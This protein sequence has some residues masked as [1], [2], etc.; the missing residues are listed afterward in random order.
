[1]HNQTC[2]VQTYVVQKAT[3][4]SFMTQVTSGIDQSALP[5]LDKNYE[6]Y[7][8]IMQI[9]HSTFYISN[10]IYLFIHLFIKYMLVAQKVHVFRVT[11]RIQ[12]RM[13]HPW[14]SEG[15]DVAQCKTLHFFLGNLNRKTQKKVNKQRLLNFNP[16]YICTSNAEKGIYFGS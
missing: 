14:S 10:N 4:L 9:N 1:M 15:T 2:I 8:L 3:A 6:I 12:L 5:L 7:L 13:A 11:Q 16:N